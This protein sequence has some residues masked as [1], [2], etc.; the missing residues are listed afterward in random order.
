MKNNGVILGGIILLITVLA[1]VGGLLIFTGEDEDNNIENDNQSVTDNQDQS[2]ENSDNT[3][4]IQDDDQGP[5]SNS[6]SLADLGVSFSV[7]LEVNETDNPTVY[8]RYPVP[9]NCSYLGQSEDRDLIV[10]ASE[11]GSDCIIKDNF[12]EIGNNE[13]ETDESTYNLSRYSLEGNKDILFLEEIEISNGITLSF[14]YKEKYGTD[15]MGEIQSI[16]DSY[17]VEITQ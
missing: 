4:R 14:L 12:S 3:S 15:V 13:I 5:T 16:L 8:K 2:E 1:V 7:P 10:A 11:T 17:E 9:S 6:V